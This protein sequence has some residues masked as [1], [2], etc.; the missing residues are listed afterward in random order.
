MIGCICWSLLYFVANS[1]LS[2][3]GCPVWVTAVVT[4][5]IAV[6]LTA[7]CWR[8]D[9]RCR[10]SGDL[11]AALPLLVFAAAN[12]V[13]LE[14]LT[15]SAVWV[16]TLVGAVVEEL[17]FRGLLLGALEKKNTHIAIACSTLL[18]GAY[19]WING[20]HWQA[21]CAVCFGFALAVYMCRFRAVW[22]CVAVH[23][24]TNAFGNAAVPLWLLLLCCVICS[25]YGWVLY[26]R[27]KEI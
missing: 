9:A 10:T 7:F 11:C 1:V 12:I 16:C 21:L 5:C 13:F 22:P 18:F 4:A 25:I 2:L 20:G 27:K 17:L 3:L 24:L 15:F 8:K 23:V 6:S 26:P 14:T 19:H